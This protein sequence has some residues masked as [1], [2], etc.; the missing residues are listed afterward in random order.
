MAQEGTTHKHKS[1]KHHNKNKKNKKHHHNKKDA[2]LVQKADPIKSETFEKDFIANS[3][4]K[5]VILAE[6]ARDAEMLVQT[7][8]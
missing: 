6:D 4:E 7:A 5:K 8:S 3:N 1:H 2:S